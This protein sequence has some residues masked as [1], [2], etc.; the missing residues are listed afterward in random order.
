MTAKFVKAILRTTA[1]MGAGLLLS[2][3]VSYAADVHVYLQAARQVKS[4][5]DSSTVPMWYYV[6]TPGAASNANCVTTGTGSARINA[7]AGDSLT[8]HLSNTLNTPTS[9]IIPGQAGGSNIPTTSP[10]LRA[11][12]R[13]RSFTHETADN[14][15]ASG[16]VEYYWA[17]LRAGSYLYQSGTRS[18][19]QVP[20]GLY[21]A[22]VVD[23]AGCTAPQKAAYGA[24]TCY[25]N[26]ALLLLSEIDPVQNARSDTAMLNL[27][28]G[29]LPTPACVK[30]ADAAT[31]GYPCT[32]DYTPT[33]FLVNGEVYDK[34]AP[35]TSLSAG[36]PGGTVLVR[37]LNAGL[38]SHVP[39]IVGLQMGLVAEDGFV[40]PGT[41]RQQSEALLGAGKTRDV[42]VVTPASCGSPAATCN[43]TYPIFDRMPEANA[44]ARPV[45]GMLT[46]LIAG[47]GGTPMTTVPTVY[48][49]NDAFAVDE[50]TPLINANVLTNDPGLATAT[51]T[52]ISPP[53][54]GVV[55]MNANGV[56][57]YTPNENFS[58]T[59]TFLYSAA[60]GGSNYPA[61]VTL[62][63]SF[64]QDPPV[65]ADDSYTNTIGAGISEAAP[66]VLG[67]DK[68]ADGDDISAVALAGATTAA[69]GTVTL[70]ADGSFVYTPPAVPGFAPGADSFSYQVTDG[71]ST[72]S[73]TVYLTVNP[74]ANIALNVQEPPSGGTPGAAV[75]SYRWVLQEDATYHIDPLSPPPNSNTLSTSF[76][77]SYMP[78]VAQGCVGAECATNNPNVPIAAFNQVALDPTK[79]YYVSVLPNDAGNGD[80]H[81][82]GGTQIPTGASQVTVIV[83][84]QPIPTAQLSVLVF[85]DVAPTNGVPDPTDPRLGGFTVILED[86]GG[87]YGISGGTMSQDAFGNPLMNALGLPVADGGKDCFA[88]STPPPAGVILT[89][90][91]T[92]A[93]QAAGVVG[94]VLVRDLQ[95]GKYGVIAV[96]PQGGATWV[97]TSTIEGTKVIDAWVKAGEPPYFVE[98]GV[99]SFHAFIGFVNPDALVK[100]AGGTNTITGAITPLHAARPP[101]MTG[102]DSGSYD[103]LGHTRAWVGLNSAAGTGPNIAAVHAEPDGTF[104]I[105]EV[106]DGLYQLVI[107]DDY[108]DQIIFYQSVS[109][110]GGVTVATGNIS[111][112]TWFGRHEHTVFLDENENGIRDEGEPGLP[113]QAV[114]IRWRDGTV[115]QSF[116]TDTTGFV[117]FDQVF[118]FGSWQVA[119]ID[120]TRFKPTGVTVI[121][122][123]GGDVSGDGGIPGRDYTGLLNPQIQG[124]CTEQDVDSGASGCMTIGQAYA[125][126]K[127]RTETGPVLT[128]GFQSNPG[129][130]TIFE[131]GKKPYAVGENGGIAG[132]VFYGSTRGENDPR[133][134]VGDP[135]EPGIPG[136]RVRLY[137]E[138]AKS[139]GGTALALVEEVT[140]DK[141]DISLPNG[142]AGEPA[143]PN[144]FVDV[145][146]AGDASRCFDGVRNWEQVRPAIF[147]GGYAFTGLAPGKYVV[148]VVPPRGYE[149]IKEEDVNV[150]FGDAFLMM[151]PGGGECTTCPD[152]LTVLAATAPEPGLLQPPCVG[153]MRTVGSELS[154][155][156]GVETPYAGLSR[157]L[158]NR[159]AVLLADQSQAGADFHLFTST[160]VAG[161]AAGLTTD[162]VA[163]EQNPASP[164]FGDKWGP[165]YM[166]FSMRDFL[167][168]EVYRGYTDAFGRYNAM[169]PSTFTA[170]IPVPS[171]YS[172]GMHQVCLN[173]PGP[174]PGPGGTMIL[175]PKTNPNYG[176]AC[177]TLMYMP[178]ATTYLDTPLL[179]SAAFAAGFNSVDCAGDQGMPKI[180]RVEG[181][182]G[183]PLVRPGNPGANR[184][185]TIYAQ[186]PTE[187][188]NP[189]YEGPL[190][191]APFNQATI[192][193]DFGFGTQT[194]QVRVVY[195]STPGN[196][197]DVAGNVESWTN[198]QIV[199]LVPGSLPS[200]S[201]AELVVV[202]GDNGMRSVNSVTLTRSAETPI[203]VPTPAYPTIQSAID[204]ATPGS[205]ILVAPGAYEEQVVMWKPVRL[206]GYGAATII[207]AVKRPPEKLEAWRNKVQGL[208]D[209]GSVSL[210]PGQDAGA[211]VPVEGP[212]GPLQTEQGAGVTVLAYA[213]PLGPNSYLTYPSRIDGFTIT[214]ADGGGGIFVN[215]Y[216]HNL[217]IA[218]NN[219]TKNVGIL[220]GGIRVGHPYLANPEQ[221]VNMNVNI[222][223]NSVTR[224]GNQSDVGVG[225]GLAMSAGSTGYRAAENFVCGNFSLGHGGGISHLGLSNN[226]R[227][228]FNDVRFNQSFN[229]GLTRNGGGIYV[230]G[231]APAAGGLTSGSGNVAVT[232]NR[233]QG[234]QAGSGH[235]GGIRAESVNGAEPSTSRWSLTITNNMV[236]NNVAGWSG[237]GISLQDAVNV[238][239]RSN[240]IANND[241]TATA[242]PLVAA[243]ATTSAPQP[244]GVSSEP[245]SLALAAAVGAG[246]SN[247]E[248]INNIVWHNRSFSYD[249]TAG[250]AQLL[251]VLNATAIGQCPAGANYWDLGVLGEAINSAVRLNPTYSLLSATTAAIYT[252]A[253]NNNPADDDPQ[254]GLAYCNG[255]RTLS[256]PGPMQVAAE[257]IEGGN[258]I[259]VRYGPLT[260]VWPVGGNPW[261]YH[262]GNQSD[263]RNAAQQATTPNCDF[264]RQ[265]RG[266]GQKDIGAD[267]VTNSTANSTACY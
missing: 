55:A 96:P 17:S 234:N 192:V 159:K 178:G 39:A 86:A 138:V 181:P 218:N 40:H 217:V 20:M 226:G 133:L 125:N 190:A 167:G 259:D 209:N 212:A 72:T 175:D 142:C 173:D 245:H 211:I 208:I 119:E 43:A 94:Q 53:T 30:L 183:G 196:Y 143:S 88:G 50:D 235:G 76:H 32:I 29:T 249:A 129:M 111:V 52:V 264:D 82:I 62:N 48:A 69:G 188:A 24:A 228:L 250:A 116:P 222:H 265:E 108:L 126:P 148:E 154:L 195:E 22:L 168:N 38:R 200:P 64:V 63:V 193:R 49:A 57:T 261:N 185:I 233:V 112:P 134:T 248:L 101:S 27:P 158:C 263:A 149:L 14:T 151:L 180:T 61:Q 171:G 216:A 169:L 74:I 89:C 104:S 152:F 105:G 13:V 163:V 141:W 128:Q 131:W 161:Q 232:G 41:V 28:A 44:D 213:D 45:G 240:T 5:P 165:A 214:S 204:G 9:V 117:P 84:K 16:A 120:F 65:A 256:A 54:N 153:A 77:R 243:A 251:P 68:D 254:F 267:E 160:P 227:I 187:V 21:G 244:A 71:T 150:G 231:E 90:P 201:S 99:P 239:I 205:L 18:P 137:K 113:E 194:G 70:N 6:C 107:W 12:E 97:Q 106:P 127:L 25:D 81:S 103:A 98:F 237:G 123:G 3:G 174:I 184:R 186:G 207:N 73:A 102:F 224:N 242:G 198:T 136:V 130:N 266:N 147:D 100:P 260:Q 164:S 95:P 110:S 146:L 114:N 156:P 230:A 7:N 10:D 109:V 172:P 219:I 23:A 157:P 182:E 80:G 26:E 241:S 189:A 91:N 247:P 2:A 59:D 257:V 206:Q 236:V 92:V 58:G 31:T 35:T 177:Y 179:P 197:V 79:R 140:T 155:F 118:P 166:P 238:S 145:T 170:N 46:Y 225:G 121:V 34:S 67:N 83:A 162:D 11:R 221:N 85:E 252:G 8:I 220:H 36:T 144:A 1:L 56:F 258:F 4:L 115:N 176:S 47:S 33:Y 139:G 246:F 223:H 75:G 210:V 93:N 15:P 215:G 191:P 87:R 78:V 202:R 124:P 132:I 60:L 199:A 229:P 51:V 19:I 66:G 135:W 253:N 255:A 37:L 203:R 262:I 42:L 122:D